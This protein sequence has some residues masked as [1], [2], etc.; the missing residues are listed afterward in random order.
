MTISYIPTNLGLSNLALF[1]PAASRVAQ[2][3]R[4][5]SALR[6]PTEIEAPALRRSARRPSQELAQ[7]ARRR[8]G[9][10]SAKEVEASHPQSGQFA[11]RSSKDVRQLSRND[12]IKSH[13]SGTS[14]RG[15]LLGAS[16]PKRTPFSSGLRNYKAPTVRWLVV[17]LFYS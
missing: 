7:Q 1:N 11:L 2:Q 8:S 17:I 3:A 6:A 12:S 14:Q 13:E 5:R 9:L 15:Q 4:R 16:S 10:R